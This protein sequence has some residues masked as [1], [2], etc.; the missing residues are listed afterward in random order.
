MIHSTGFISATE[1]LNFPGASP[2]ENCS[3][4]QTALQR[5][6]I[7]RL[8][9]HLVGLQRFILALLAPSFERQLEHS[10]SWISHDLGENSSP[11]G[12]GVKVLPAGVDFWPSSGGGWK[13]ELTWN[14]QTARCLSEGSPC[15]RA[16]QASHSKKIMPVEAARISEHPNLAALGRQDGTQSALASRLAFTAQSP[17]RSPRPACE[18]LGL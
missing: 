10:A 5:N 12:G 3:P 14:W 17:G 8:D 16:L 7:D 13:A 9:S 11:N 2:F 4:T 18:H 15:P 6:R 1:F